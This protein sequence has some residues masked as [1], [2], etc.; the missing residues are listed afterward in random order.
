MIRLALFATHPIQYHIPW[1]QALDDRP[2]IDLTVYYDRIPD[3]KEQGAGFGE[4]FEWDVP[5][6][7]GYQ[8]KVRRS[9]VGTAR[10]RQFERVRSAVHPSNTDVVLATGWYD[11]FLRRAAIAAAAY[12]QPLLVRGESSAMKSR[13]LWVRIV[14][15]SY[16]SLFDR[17]LVIGTA[18]WKFY[19]QYGISPRRMFSCPYFVH[20]TR[21]D[22]QY[23]ELSPRR[24]KLREAFDIPLNAECMLFAGKFVEKKRP[25]DVL[26]ALKNAQDNHPVYGL[27]VGSG[28]LENQLRNYA[29]RNDVPV[30]FT[31]FLNQT[32]IA[33]A[34]T[35]AD[36]LV[37]PSNY[38]ETWGLVVNEAMMFEC[39]AIV[40]DRVGC[41]PDL[42]DDGA[43]G[44]TFPFGD[45]DALA[46]QMQKVAART[47]LR[48]EMGRQARNRVL[49]KH[50]VE[51]TVEGTISAMHSTVE[52]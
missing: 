39:P 19:Q 14:H 23:Q 25:L 42:V 2:E 1:F 40:S 41:G 37:L 28:P 22:R 29:R 52:S 46:D 44:Y 12:R 43:T 16:L 26:K 5:L 7:E 31:G 50:T 20:N 18:N 4:A 3:E 17:F 8:W 47:Q 9:P 36:T 35:A 13:P 38:D 48:Q 6:L 21:F 34:Y 10:Q 33:K 32:E 27:M 51:N 24:R 45:V 15:W 49:D 11:D 30:T